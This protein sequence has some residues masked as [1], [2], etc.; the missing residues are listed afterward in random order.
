MSYSYR[1]KEG[2][3]CEDQFGAALVKSRRVTPLTY[4]TE[5]TSQYIRPSDMDD[6]RTSTKGIVVDS[7]YDLKIHEGW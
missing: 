3:W 5:M 1:T 2:N 4:V 6:T 7:V